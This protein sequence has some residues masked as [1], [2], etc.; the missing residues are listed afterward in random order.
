MLPS[1]LTLSEDQSITDKMAGVPVQVG[2]SAK[3]ASS[4]PGSKT[5]IGN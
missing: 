4:A 5:D 1:H 2:L 3:V